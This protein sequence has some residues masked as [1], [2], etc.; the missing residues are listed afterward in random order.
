MFTSAN[1]VAIRAL[2]TRAPE[3]GNIL[4]ACGSPCLA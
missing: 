1:L 4:T 2:L 3:P